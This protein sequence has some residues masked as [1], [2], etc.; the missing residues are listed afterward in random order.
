MLDAQLDGDAA[1]R[2]RSALLNWWF[3][4]H[5]GSDAQPP[6]VTDMLQWAESHSRPLLA[7]AEP[8]VARA[9]LEALSRRLDGKPAAGATATQKR[10][11]LVTALSWAVEQGYLESNPVQAVR[12]R[13]PR[14]AQQVDRRVVVNPQQARSL[15]DAVWETLP[16]GPRLVAFF[17]LLYFS[18][19]RPE[20]AVNVREQDLWLP[21]EG[22]GRVVLHKAAPEVDRQWTDGNSR[23]QERQLKHRAQGETRPV[24]VPPARTA[25]STPP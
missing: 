18:A 2:L 3:T 23:R 8:D 19:L 6:S 13:A 20:E 14:A 7:I 1:K 16:S 17:G 4:S 21:V 5:R 24:P 12:W 15:L 25:D 9:V 10:A 22:W 11:N